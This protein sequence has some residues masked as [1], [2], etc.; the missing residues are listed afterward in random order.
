MEVHGEVIGRSW[1]EFMSVDGEIYPMNSHNDL[2]VTPNEVHELPM[3]VRGFL[4]VGI[5]C[6]GNWVKF[7]F[8]IVLRVD[9]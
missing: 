3:N 9:L 8:S 7:D 6:C 1:S 4:L 2:Q 5:R